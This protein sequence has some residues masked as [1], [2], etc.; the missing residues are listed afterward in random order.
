[1]YDDD[2]DDD[3]DEDM[4]VGH[5]S[6]EEEETEEEEDLIEIDGDDDPDNDN[7]S[8]VSDGPE[9]VSE[10]EGE[11]EER[12]VKEERDS[13]LILDS[14]T[15][16]CSAAR[17][18]SFTL[19]YMCPATDITYTYPQASVRSY[20]SEYCAFFWILRNI[21]DTAKGGGG[22]VA[23]HSERIFFTSSVTALMLI[24]FIIQRLQMLATQSPDQMISA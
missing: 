18:V 17:S 24:S 16:R 3:D 23:S 2:D 9:E 14:Q 19:R 7:S 8:N 13:R 15:T 22:Q 10:S 21:G 11:L 1:M 4:E 6:S 5:E 20:A 12:R